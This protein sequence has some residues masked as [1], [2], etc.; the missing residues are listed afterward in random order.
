M[1]GF[2]WLNYVAV[3]RAI[4]LNGFDDGCGSFCWGDDGGVVCVPGEDELV[5]RIGGVM[6][7]VNFFYEW[8][9][10]DAVEVHRKRVTLLDSFG[11]DDCC[12]CVVVLAEYD[13]DLV[14]IAVK[15]KSAYFWPD[16]PDG[17]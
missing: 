10:G 2:F 8:G 4:L 15:S 7:L 9:E 16:V 12:C 6:L 11:A 1:D 5:W 3:G 13:E 17:P 14:T